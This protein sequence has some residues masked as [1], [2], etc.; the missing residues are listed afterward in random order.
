[1]VQRLKADYSLEYDPGLK[2]DLVN[3]FS[4]SVGRKN[5]IGREKLLKLLG[6]KGRADSK[7]GLA[8][9]ERKVRQAIVDLRHDGMLICSTGG[10]KGG[11]WLAEDWDDLREFTQREYH[12]RA[13]SMLETEKLMKQA[14]AAR[15]GQEPAHQPSL[16][17]VN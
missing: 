9:F 3:I 10:K 11:Y 16:F 4:Q 15:W 5:A 8:D 7:L 13:M 12:A 2:R 17:K 6:W 14:A 1:M